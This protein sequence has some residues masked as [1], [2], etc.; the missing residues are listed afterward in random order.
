MPLL[1]SAWY[2]LRD[3]NPRLMLEKH[4]SLAKLDEGGWSG[5][6]ESNWRPYA[7]EAYALPSCAIPRGQSDVNRTHDPR[8]PRPV[9]YL[10]EL[11]SVE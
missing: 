9:L 6:P 1:Y 4:P 3:L 10:A 2:L 5:K 7:P 8:L 11:H